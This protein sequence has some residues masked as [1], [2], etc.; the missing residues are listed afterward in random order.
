MLGN[1]HVRFGGGRMKKGCS[2][3][4]RQPS[5]LQHP[6]KSFSMYPG[7]QGNILF[8]GGGKRFWTDCLYSYTQTGYEQA[9]WMKEEPPSMY[10]GECQFDQLDMARIRRH[11]V[12]RLEQLGYTVTLTAKEAA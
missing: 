1:Q 11:H 10:G 4:P 7:A 8:F 6:G 9:G 12:R 3:V 5:T 2:A